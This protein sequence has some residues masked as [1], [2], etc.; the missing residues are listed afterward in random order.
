VGTWRHQGV[1]R[2]RA[3]RE[4]GAAAVEMAL[5]LP[6][7]L[8]VVFGIIEF[9]FAF[10]AQIA[11]TQAVREGVR[12]G[13]IGEAPSETLMGTRMGEAYI[14]V[15]GA[16]PTVENA[17]ACAPDDTDGQAELTGAIAYETPIGRFGPFTLR[18]TAVMRCGG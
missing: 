8:I 15:T 14:G 7:L 17:V 5:I 11:L 16:A 1:R 4:D 6:V 13:A 18:A 2:R 9:G 12:V 10:N 3:G